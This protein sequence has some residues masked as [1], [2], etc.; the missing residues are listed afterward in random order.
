MSGRGMAGAS[1]CL[2]ANYALSFPRN[3]T[4]QLTARALGCRSYQIKP[5]KVQ[6]LAKMEQAAH[7]SCP[8]EKLLSSLP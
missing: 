7:I 4:P 6:D 2:C 3:T 1:D 8:P 5:L